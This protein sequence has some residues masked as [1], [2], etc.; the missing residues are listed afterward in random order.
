MIRFDTQVKAS[1]LEPRRPVDETDR[2]GDQDRLN[3]SEDRPVTR[4]LRRKMEAERDPEIRRDLAQRLVN[5]Q[6]A[7][8][9]EETER[10]EGSALRQAGDGTA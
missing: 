1:A 7:A 3:D 2:L 10:E 9:A 4:D 6:D 5:R 8:R